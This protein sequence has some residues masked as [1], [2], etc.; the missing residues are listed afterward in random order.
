MTGTFVKVPNRDTVA[1]IAYVVKDNFVLRND[2]R[3]ITSMNC[4][5]PMDEFANLT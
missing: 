1:A 3:S 2:L 4:N 5:M